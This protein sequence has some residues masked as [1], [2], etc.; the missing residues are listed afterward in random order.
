MLAAANV[1]VA[2]TREVADRVESTLEAAWLEWIERNGYKPPTGS[3]Q[4]IAAANTRP[5]FLYGGEAAIYIDGPVHLYPDRMVRDATTTAA[6]QSLGYTVVRFG[7]EDDWAQI[8]DTYKWI[9][10]EGT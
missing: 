4:Y 8:A 7:H 6:M 5:D 3:Q 1:S 10:G 2:T 9:F